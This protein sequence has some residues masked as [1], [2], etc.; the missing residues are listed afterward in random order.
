MR[1]EFEY[2]GADVQTDGRSVIVGAPDE[3]DGGKAFVYKCETL[4]NIWLLE[5]ELVPTSVGLSA[6][7]NFGHSVS[8]FGDYAIVGN[9]SHDILSN[10]STLPDAGAAFIFKRGTTGL[11]SEVTMLQE[12]SLNQDANFGWSV[13]ISSNA[14]D[15]SGDYDIPIPGTQFNAV[16]GAPTSNA[17][18]GNMTGAVHISSPLIQQ[19]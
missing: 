7:D 5:D 17:V 12:P 9:P 13:D 4:A 3:Y 8:I 2:F 11:W 19:E 14:I 16:V 10:G 6:D 1:D 18:N 15:R